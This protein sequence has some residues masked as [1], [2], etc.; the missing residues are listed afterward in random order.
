[1]TN[2]NYTPPADLG[3]VQKIATGVGLIGIIIW[4][5]GA[6]VSGHAKDTFF[7]SYLVAFV[8]WTGI[9]LGCLGLLMIQ[10]LGGASW[11]L[12]IRR[13]LEAGSSALW[14]MFILFLPIAIF[15]LHSLYVWIDPSAIQNAAELKLIEHKSAWLNQKGF[16]IRGVI[17]FAIWIGLA[18]YLLKWSRQQDENRDMGATQR[19]QNL[20]GPGF[21]I[22]SLAITFAGVDWVMSLDVEWYSTIFGLLMLIGQGVAALAFVITI[23]VY[24][25]DREP[26]SRVYQNKHFHDLGKLLLAAVMVWAYFSFSQLLIV[27]SG[28][29]PEEI[30]W[31]LE[32]FRG[33]WRWMGVALILLHFALPFVLLLSRDLKHNR[34]RLMMVAWLLIV[35]RFID[36]IWLI[37]PEFERGHGGQAAH[38]GLTVASYINYAAAMVGVGGLWLG[39]FFYRLR[40][41][42]LVP[43]NDPQVGEVLARGEHL[44]SFEGY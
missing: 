14:L 3:R 35:M 42:A 39:W 19:S 38:Y 44:L 12:L 6:V 15:G 5:V 1:M 18:T 2:N 25:S 23:G 43:Y 10:Y 33:Q 26:M 41:R 16:L 36:L 22:Y 34:R 30:P 7:R 24:L 20:S 11:G 13:Q 8:F 29:L 40:Q 28:N 27:W 9:A 17:Y 37:A 21:V 4:I 31:Y 32:R